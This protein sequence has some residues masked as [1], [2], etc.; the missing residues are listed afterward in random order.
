VSVLAGTVVTTTGQDPITLAT[1][2]VLAAAAVASALTPIILARRRARKEALKAAQASAVNSSELTL[3]GWTAL[4]AAL[5]QEITRLQSVQ[6]RMQQRIDL[7]E[8]EI[9]ALQKLAIEKTAPGA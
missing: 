9:A 4:N 7:L 2:I 3:A 5:Q 1:E 6:E 8:A